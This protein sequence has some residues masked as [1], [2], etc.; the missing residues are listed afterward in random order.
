MISD[1]SEKPLMFSNK[2]YE[3]GENLILNKPRKPLAKL[4]YPIEV[5]K[6]VVE[7]NTISIRDF[8]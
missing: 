2:I 6:G 7:Y 3:I 5:Y 8:R 4:F 1:W